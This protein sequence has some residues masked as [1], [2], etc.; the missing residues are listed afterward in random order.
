MP[1]LNKILND[2]LELIKRE[3]N[4][5]NI[6]ILADDDTHPLGG[7]SSLYYSNSYKAKNNKDFVYQVDQFFKQLKLKNNIS[8]DH[9]WKKDGFKNLDKNLRSK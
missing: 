4:A 5:K 3:T 2:A 9:D 1:K 8:I 6:L 7:G